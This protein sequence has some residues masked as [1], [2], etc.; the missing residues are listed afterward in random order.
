MIDSCRKTIKV[1][2]CGSD[3]SN[4]SEPIKEPFSVC[5][6][7]GRSL[8]YDG[9]TIRLHGKSN[10][11]DGTYGTITVENGCIVSAG[12]QPVCEYTPQPCAPASATCDGTSSNP[13]GIVLDPRAGNIATLDSQ[14]RLGA[15]IHYYAGANITITGTGTKSDPLR[16]SV[17]GGGEGGA[18][19]MISGTPDVI[20]LSGSGTSQDTYVIEHSALKDVSGTYGMFTFDKFGHLTNVDTSVTGNV[21]AVIGDNNTIDVNMTGT[22]ATVSMKATNYA[23]GIYNFGGYSAEVSQYG[24]I[25]DVKQTIDLGGSIQIDASNYYINVNR[26]GSVIGVSPKSGG[27]G[28]ETASGKTV[29]V[30]DGSETNASTSRKVL[31][32]NTAACKLLIKY[33]G[34]LMTDGNHNPT[35]GTKNFGVRLD[36]EEL[37]LEDLYEYG[38][39]YA[40]VDSLVNP[41]EHTIEFWATRNP[42]NPGQGGFYTFVGRSLIEIEAVKIVYPEG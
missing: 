25:I 20:R 18:C 37:Y 28:S 8:S 9:E 41:G 21:T 38:V 12:E 27:G 34:K 5:L 40:S 24:T 23:K 39:V 22:I 31:Y 13:T 33:T 6:P 3:V 7:F 16:F 15:F 26:Y 35:T 10:I 1:T 29:S 11:P 32:T 17:T 42:Y 4:S 19:Y 2:D 36:G 30:F 14:G